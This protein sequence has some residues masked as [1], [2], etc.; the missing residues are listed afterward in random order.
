MV[1]RDSTDGRISRL[2]EAVLNMKEDRLQ[3]RTDR[4]DILA[5]IKDVKNSLSSLAQNVQST[6]QA[7]AQLSL[8]RCGERLE[9]HDWRIAELEKKTENLPVIETE[10]M[11]W[12]RVLG[13]GFHAA[14]KIAAVILSSGALGGLSVKMLWPH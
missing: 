10:V 3:S 11:F 5:E 12:R 1:A 7:V 9:R 6:G 13:G 8:E 2:E 14:W 4:A